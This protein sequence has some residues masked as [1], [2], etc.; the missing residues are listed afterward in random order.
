GHGLGTRFLRH[1]E[2]TRLLVHLV[3]ISDTGRDPADD[4]RVVRNELHQFSTALAEKPVV[5]AANKLDALPNPERLAALRAHCETE[6]LP[7]VAISA[8]TGE[9][10]DELRRLLA[11]QLRNLAPAAPATPAP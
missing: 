1:I 2:R 4:F 3:D 9:G 5:V 8:V 7:C 10:L 11:A 6:G